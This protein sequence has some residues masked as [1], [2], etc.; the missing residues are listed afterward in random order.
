MKLSIQLKMFVWSDN[1]LVHRIDSTESGMILSSE[2][3]QQIDSL[4]LIVD[5]LQGKHWQMDK[6]RNKEFS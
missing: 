3:L 4:V 2:Q 5:S 6:D 1:H